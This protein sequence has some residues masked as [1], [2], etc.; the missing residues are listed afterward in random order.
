[1][2]EKIRGTRILFLLFFLYLNKGKDIRLSDLRRISGYKSPSAIYNAIGTL[3]DKG[4]IEELT[5][6]H[7]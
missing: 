2:G 3:L 7:D 1:M 6:S 5:Y 4:L